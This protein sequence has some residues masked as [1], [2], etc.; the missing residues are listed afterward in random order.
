VFLL[1]NPSRSSLI[2]SSETGPTSVEQIIVLRY[3][4]RLLSLLT[5]VR[6]VGKGLAGTNTLAY[7][8]G[9]VDK[10]CFVTLTLG[11]TDFRQSNNGEN[12]VEVH[13]GVTAIILFFFNTDA[14]A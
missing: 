1:G 4:G 11:G 9:V 2:F 3:I 6:L 14:P 5:N 7:F 10:E 8:G 13:P 12:Q